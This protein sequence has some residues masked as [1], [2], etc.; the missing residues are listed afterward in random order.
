LA[1]T[2]KVF[3]LKIQLPDENILIEGKLNYTQNGQT[4]DMTMNAKIRDAGIEVADISL[5]NH[6]VIEYIQSLNITAPQDAISIEGLAEMM[7]AF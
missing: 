1:N 5:K 7:P 2:T 3:D 4:R 6:E